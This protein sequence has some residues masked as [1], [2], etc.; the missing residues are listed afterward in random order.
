[1][2]G[3]DA[4]V[5]LLR[6][7]SAIFLLFSLLLVAQTGLTK[8]PEFDL[9]A[10]ASLLMEV[11]SN[12]IIWAENSHERLY[13]ASL[14]KI[15][16]LL[17]VIEQLEQKY[18]FLEDQV[19]ISARASAMGGSELFLSEGDLVS[20]GDLLI[21][22]AVGSANDAAVAVAEH[23]GG[24]V[25]SFVE[26]MNEKARYL[27]MENTNFLNPHG[28]H[29]PEHYSSAYDIM[30][31]SLAILEYPQIHEWATVWMDEHFLKGKIKSGEVF[32]SNTN[33]LVYSYPGC[34]GLK[35]GFTQEAGNGIAATARRNQTRF[36][37][38]VLGAPTVKERYEAAVTLLNYGFSR[39]KALPIVDKNDVVATV[40]VDKGKPASL[41]LVAKNRFGLLLPRGA[42][43]SFTR[44]IV[45]ASYRLPIRK[46]DKLGELVVV[47]SEGNKLSVELVAAAD[48]NRASPT[49]IFFRLLNR[50][51]RFG[52]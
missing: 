3:S 29:H 8:E 28:L 17:V 7:G 47:C 33:R 21:G 24:S 13:P 20:L 31:M 46:G 15:M 45:L 51:L 36:L 12:K 23:I 41:D 37:A 26:M 35:T 16:S 52:R 1:M 19:Q 49:I 50:W 44:E 22:M 2:K 4:A 30:L 6:F 32:L 18:F 39:Y 40:T 27:G 10:Q 42:E 43:E 34:D 38:V 5:K 9:K 48:V 14:T 11:N 25:E